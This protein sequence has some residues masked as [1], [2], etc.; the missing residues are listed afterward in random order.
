VL[1]FP[2]GWLQFGDVSD[3]DDVATGESPSATVTATNTAT[4]SVTSGAAAAVE[5]SSTA[6]VVAQ[7]PQQQQQ[8]R[9][10]SSSSSVTAIGKQ[11]AQAAEA[12]LYAAAAEQRVAELAAARNKCIGEVALLAQHVL[13][14]TAEW[15]HSSSSSSSAASSE[16]L[17]QTA[18][19]WYREARHLAA[20]I[21]D[22]QCKLYECCTAEQ[23]KQLLRGAHT[24]GTAELALTVQ[25]GAAVEQADA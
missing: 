12:Q 9:K 19:K 11:E 18:D 7:Q 6:L 23:L 22:E 25:G 16:G 8:R 3:V 1:K 21:A 15:V 10:V 13:L 17:L 2:G 4:D 20:V 14:S 5:S 24:S